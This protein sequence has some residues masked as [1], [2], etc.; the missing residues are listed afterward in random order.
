MTTNTTPSI[1]DELTRDEK[2]V[3]LY[4]ETCLVDGGGLMAGARMNEADIAALKRFREAGVLDFGRIPFHTLNEL[5][6]PAVKLTHWVR[7]HESA[8]QLAHA[9]RRQ[10]AANSQSTNRKKVD[11]ALAEKVEA[12]HV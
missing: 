11:A 6:Q 3:L 9:L 8:W 2:S 10:R 4:A 12:A 5:I 7:F 1:L